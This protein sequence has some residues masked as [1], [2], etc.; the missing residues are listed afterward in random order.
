VDAFGARS[1][2]PW[3]ANRHLRLGLLLAGL[4]AAVLAL[5]G[6]RGPW[7]GLDGATAQAGLAAIPANCP[8]HDA[9]APRTVAAGELGALGRPLA[10]IMPARVGRIYESG[11]IATGNLWSD[12]TPQR[13]PSGGDAPTPAGYEIRWWALDREGAEDDVAADALEFSSAGQAQ[14]TLRLA[15][16]PRCRREGTSS[17]LRYPGGARE[18]R[19]VNPDGVREW[20]VLL[21][22]GRRLY[23]VTDVPPEYLLTTTGRQ[24]ERRERLRDGATPGALACALPGAGCPHGAGSLEASSLAA[25]PRSPRAAAL[26]P[27]PSAAAAADYGYAVNLRGY[28]VPDAHAIAPEAPVVDSEYWQAFAHCNGA[29]GSPRVLASIRSP[30]FRMGSADH[31]DLVYSAVV[32]F[33]GDAPAER[34][35]SAAS[36]PR[37][38]ECL[39]SYYRR[40][41]RGLASKRAEASEDQVRI[42]RITAT[43]PTTPTP[44]TYRGEA[45]YRAT[46]LRVELQ[47][48]YRTRRGRRV[49]VPFYLEGFLFADGPAVIELSSQS[50]GH[51][52]WQTDERFLEATLVGRAEAHEAEL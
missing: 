3:W 34:Y 39:A 31:Y 13:L 41:T 50:L 38:R 26:G 32:V 35:L 37:A 16:S 42:G 12:D 47:A 43:A 7:L 29:A 28:L 21:A 23:R 36:S 14:Q 33:P 11:S 2:L 44:D 40:H 1:T 10:A 9:P 4:L 49:Q 17:A 8:G 25:L 51:P 6:A 46:A 19:W 15:A 24:Q 18:L 5:L 20:D 52:F 22:R 27:S 30:L 45:P 48:T